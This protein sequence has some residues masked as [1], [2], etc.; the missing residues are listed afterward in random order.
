[1][2]VLALWLAYEQGHYYPLGE[3]TPGRHLYGVGL[4]QNQD[5]VPALDISK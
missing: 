2:R 5:R 4:V 3:P 1:M